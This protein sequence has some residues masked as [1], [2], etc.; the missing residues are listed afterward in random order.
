[1]LEITVYIFTAMYT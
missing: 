1:M